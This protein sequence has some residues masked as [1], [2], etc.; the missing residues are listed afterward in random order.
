[1]PCHNDDEVCQS[2]QFIK[3]SDHCQ[4]HI[5]HTNRFR[6][7]T[8]KGSLSSYRCDNYINKRKSVWILLFISIVQRVCCWTCIVVFD[9]IYQP[10]FL[11]MCSQHIESK[12]FIEASRIAPCMCDGVICNIQVFFY[13]MSAPTHVPAI[14]VHFLR[15]MA[16]VDELQYTSGFRDNERPL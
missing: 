12:L 16:V 9:D 4:Q 8:L 10:P 2:K 7:Y 3:T 6:I 15:C 5:T 14:F 1:M 13:N 11:E